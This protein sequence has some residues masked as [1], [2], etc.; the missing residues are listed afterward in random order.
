MKS[1]IGALAALGFALACPSALAVPATVDLR[2]EGADDTIFEGRVRTDGHMIEQDRN[3]AQVCDGTNGGVNPAAGLTAT[4]ALDDGVAWDG[5]F[6]PS[7]SDFLVNRIGRDAAT[8]TQFWGFAVNGTPGELG[9][10]QVQVKNGDDVL[11]AYDMFSANQFLALSGPR[12]ARVDRPFRVR[13]TDAK[14]NN[15]PVRGASVSGVARTDS[16][17]FATIVA[18]ERGPLLVKAERNRAIRSN[19][20]VVRVR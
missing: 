11:W 7:F 10:C 9:G 4:S 12:T 13:V 15:R 19:A 8:D 17:G 16:R 1:R 20:L 2:V 18:E 5:T 3:G 14:N 6:N